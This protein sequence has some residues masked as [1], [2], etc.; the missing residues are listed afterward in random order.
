M[1]AQ[2]LEID[3][4]LEDDGQLEPL[5]IKISAPVKTDDQPDYSCLVHAPSLFGQDKKIY[6]IDRDQA[7]SLA[8]AFV[9]SLLDD[10][11]VV[12]SNRNPLIF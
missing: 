4:F 5:H 10:K 7:K 11:R 8:V 1:A 2:V 9:R 6:G 3:A 12:D